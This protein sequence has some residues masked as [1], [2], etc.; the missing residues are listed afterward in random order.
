[1]TALIAFLMAH[2]PWI[3]GGGGGLLSMAA[4]FFTGPWK[5]TLLVGGVGVVVA[6]F[7]W[8]HIDMANQRTVIAKQAASIEV[9]TDQRDYAV[10]VAERNAAAVVEARRMGERNAAALEAVHKRRIAGLERARLL[11]KEI[12]SVPED[13]KCSLSPGVR[14]L[15][16]RL[17]D[18]PASE[19]AD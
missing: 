13:Q 12:A 15:V 3:A 17:W 11:D 5:W 7:L 8:L 18:G 10:G 16:D 6:G 9:L 4:G 2:A 14:R 1:M 19:D